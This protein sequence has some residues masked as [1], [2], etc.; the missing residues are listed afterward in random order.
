MQPIKQN[1]KH[2][3]YI[4]AVQVLTKFQYIQFLFAFSIFIQLI[5]K[6]KQFL[7]EFLAGQSALKYRKLYHKYRELFAYSYTYILYQ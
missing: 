4:Q 5:E 7:L 1:N 2:M 6:I 3:S